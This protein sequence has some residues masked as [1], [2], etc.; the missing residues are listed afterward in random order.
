MNK[1]LFTVAFRKERN[2]PLGSIY[3]RKLSGRKGAGIKFLFLYAFCFY[4][5]TTLQLC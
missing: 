5:G 4:F 2:D 1:L 3:Q